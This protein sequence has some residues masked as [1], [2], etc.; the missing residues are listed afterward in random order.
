M[1]RTETIKVVDKYL[2]EPQVDGYSVSINTTGDTPDREELK[3]AIYT[4][5]DVD[6]D[7]LADEV[8]S[9]IGTVTYTDDGSI[10]SITLEEWVIEK[11]KL[12][13]F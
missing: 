6:V 12:E 5:H 3:S 7:M 13:D 11:Y 8:P 10:E 1:T 2:V 9:D 4:Q